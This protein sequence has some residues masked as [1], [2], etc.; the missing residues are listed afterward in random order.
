MIITIPLRFI[1]LAIVTILFCFFLQRKFAT[2]LLLAASGGHKVVVEV[3]IA[4]GASASDEDAVST[5]PAL[6][7]SKSDDGHTTRGQHGS[8]IMSW[9]KTKFHVKGSFLPLEGTTKHEKYGVE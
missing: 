4:H 6:T 9:D 8:V 7:P 2:P 3:L 5:R 1:N